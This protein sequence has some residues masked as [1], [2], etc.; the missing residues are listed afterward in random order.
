MSTLSMLS[1]AELLE[2]A[3]RLAASECQAT[4]ALVRC[5]IEVEDR[6]LHLAGGW[7]SMFVYCTDVLH[8]CEGTAYNRI[9]AARMAR[10]YP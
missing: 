9:H 8:L 7:G 3:Q 1:N 6:G 2:E 5:L 10:K 4:A